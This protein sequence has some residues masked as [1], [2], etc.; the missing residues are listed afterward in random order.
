[1]NF[2]RSIQKERELTDDGQLIEVHPDSLESDSARKARP[3]FKS[4]AGRVVYGGG[5]ITPDVVVPYDTLTTAEQKLARELNG[6]NVQE[7]ALALDAYALDMKTKVKPDFVVTP[8]MRDQLYQL[9]VKK[10]VTVDRKVYDAGSHY[11]DRAIDGRISGFAFGDSTAKRRQ[12]ADDA[13]LVKA[14]EILKKSTS[15]K[16]LLALAATMP[17]S[18]GKP[19]KP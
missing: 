11:I 4:D 5:A 19:N 3:K 9:L 15:T 12:V 17:G 2:G 7:T 16:E 8:E 6:K 1:L 18:T 13:Q 14:L 10:G